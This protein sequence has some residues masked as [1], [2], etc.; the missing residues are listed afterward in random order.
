MK[1]G[2]KAALVAEVYAVHEEFLVLAIPG[3]VKPEIVRVPKTTVAVKPEDIDK[4]AQA[5]MCA[6][7]FGWHRDGTPWHPAWEGKTCEH[8]SHGETWDD[9]TIEEYRDQVRAVLRSIGFKV[10]DA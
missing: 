6:T 7:D 9:S 2:D 5:I 10:E 3:R 4:A 8:P 1:I